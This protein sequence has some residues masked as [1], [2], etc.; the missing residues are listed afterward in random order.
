MAARGSGGDVDGHGAD[1]AHG[2]DDVLPGSSIEDDIIKLSVL[3]HSA[4]HA[5]TEVRHRHCRTVYIRSLRLLPRGRA[6]ASSRACVS[7][8][9]TCC[10]NAV[11]MCTLTEGLG[12]GTTAQGAGSKGQRAKKGKKGINS[13]SKV[14]RLFSLSWSLVLPH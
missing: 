12:A 14:G 7:G 5:H 9:H 3:L 4:S 2:H 6:L 1:S 10:G 11:M 8:S 13:K